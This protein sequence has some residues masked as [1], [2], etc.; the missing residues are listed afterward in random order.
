MMRRYAIRIP[1]LDVTPE[2]VLPSSAP[3]PVFARMI[4]DTKPDLIVEIGGCQGGSTVYMASLCDAEIITVDPWT[5]PAGVRALENFTRHIGSR[6][7]GR[8]VIPLQM[9]SIAAATLAAKHDLQPRLV[10]VDGGHDEANVTIDIVNWLPLI[11]AGG[12]MFG[13]D[14]NMGGVSGAVKKCLGEGIERN[15]VFWIWRVK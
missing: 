10:Y 4:D 12:I 11:P 3:H 15:G 6:K 9:N 7:L 8:R 1:D 5:G 13:H 14:H 2:T